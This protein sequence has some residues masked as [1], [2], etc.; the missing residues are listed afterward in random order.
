MEKDI[1]FLNAWRLSL[2]PTPQEGP[3]HVMSVR[4]QQIDEQNE[5]NMLEFEDQNQCFTSFFP[6]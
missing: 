3:F 5:L 6:D 2:A 4:S 1:L